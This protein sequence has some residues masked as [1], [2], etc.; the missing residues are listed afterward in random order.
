MLLADDREEG[1]FTGVTA[2]MVTLVGEMEG[3]V[4][5]EEPADDILAAEDGKSAVIRRAWALGDTDVAGRMYCRAY[6]TWPGTRRQHFPRTFALVVDI[7][8]KPGDA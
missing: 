8:R 5:L 7:R 1:I 6:I 3:Q 4:V 2:G